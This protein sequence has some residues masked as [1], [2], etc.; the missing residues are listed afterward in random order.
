MLTVFLKNTIEDCLDCAFCH[1]NVV[2]TE[3]GDN[4]SY[5][6]GHPRGM[7]NKQS[8]V[9]AIA[10]NAKPGEIGSMPIPEGCPLL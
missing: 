8:N 10:E 1:V 5:T 9:L 4:C 7:G 3:E 2:T 6:C